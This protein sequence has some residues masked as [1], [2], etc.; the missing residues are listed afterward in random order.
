[1]APEI[2]ASLGERRTF[3]LYNHHLADTFSIGLVLL[4]CMSLTD[5][6][7]AYN[8]TN[9]QIDFYY[10]ESLI[11]IAERTGYPEDLISIARECLKLRNRPTAYELL[12]KYPDLS[13]S[14]GNFQKQKMSLKRENSRLNFSKYS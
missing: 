14:K 5:P 3:P 1:M 7:G 2:L 6:L 11:R 10:I 12:L 9:Y 8:Y 4:F 13:N